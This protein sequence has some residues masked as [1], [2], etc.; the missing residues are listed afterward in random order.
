MDTSSV[1]KLFRGIQSQD[2]ERPQGNVD[3]LIGIDH[4][5]IMPQVIE[6]VGTLQ[7]LENQFGFCIRGTH[8]EQCSTEYRTKHITLNGELIQMDINT[9]RAEAIASLKKR[10]DEY[11]SVE[12]LGT[13]CTPRCGSCKCGKCGRGNGNYTLLEERELALIKQVFSTIRR[14][15]NLLF[16]TRG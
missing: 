9:I 5:V 12:N 3:M 6:T 4:C 13:C 1:A 7:L 14:K 11:F 15:E 10:L 8:D 2:I 16:I